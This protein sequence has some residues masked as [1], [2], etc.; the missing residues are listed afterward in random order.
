MEDFL[1]KLFLVKNDQFFALVAPIDEIWK[2][3]K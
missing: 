3:L 1:F 2:I